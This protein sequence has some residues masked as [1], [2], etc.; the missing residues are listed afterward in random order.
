MEQE[1]K[2]GLSFLIKAPEKCKSRPPQS[3]CWLTC[4]SFCKTSLSLRLKHPLLPSLSHALP[5]Q[6]LTPMTFSCTHLSVS[7]SLSLS[8]RQI[9][10]FLLKKSPNPEFFCDSEYSSHLYSHTM[11]KRVVFLSFS[12]AASATSF[13]NIINT[14]P[15]LSYQLVFTS[16]F[17][18]LL[19]LLFWGLPLPNTAYGWLTRSCFLRSSYC[20]IWRQILLSLDSIR[21]L[22]HTA[23]RWTKLI[24]TWRSQ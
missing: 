21:V 22:R 2:T 14:E 18:I 15:M 10:V 3:S 6:F 23:D 12:A 17:F 1:N 9:Q 24:F 16:F 7:L 8:N 19:L 11:I 5:H 20:T 13:N 4:T